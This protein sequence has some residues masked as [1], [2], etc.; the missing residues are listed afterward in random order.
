[1]SKKHILKYAQFRPILSH[2]PMSTG[3]IFK[4]ISPHENIIKFFQLKYISI[5]HIKRH[6]KITQAKVFEN[7]T[8]RQ[9][10]LVCM[11]RHAAQLEPRGK[12]EW[13]EFSP[14]LWPHILV[15]L[16][17]RIGSHGTRNGS[18]A[19]WPEKTEEHLSV[20]ILWYLSASVWFPQPFVHTHFCRSGICRTLYI[21]V[22]VIWYT[23]V[24]Y[25]VFF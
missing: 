6:Q 13:W 2:F 24:W 20:L 5:L 12:I 10:A 18:I 21:R 23:T 17:F 3:Q 19:M 4:P 14:Y 9:H 25:R 7:F 15:F 8:S 11:V 22:M 16:L 1:M